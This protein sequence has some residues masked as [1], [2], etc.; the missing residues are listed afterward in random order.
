MISLSRAL[1]AAEPMPDRAALKKVKRIAV[2]APFFCTDTLLR[3]PQSEARKTY[4]ESLQTLERTIQKRL[5]VSLAELGRFRVAPPDLT[6]RSLRALGWNPRDL[7]EEEAAL[8]GA[9]P[10]LDTERAAKLAKKLRVDAVLAA[11]MREPASTKEGYQIAR[12]TWDFNPLSIRFQRYPNHV[13]SPRVQAFL[14]NAEGKVLWQDEQMAVQPRTKPH[15]AK[16]L[17]VDWQEATL[18]VTQHLTENL[19]REAGEFKPEKK[20]I[21]G[22]R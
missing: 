14:V 9:W 2:V 21:A 1:M 4:C 8:F 11:A 15:T 22:S 10:R 7:Y 20:Q 12:N 18:L 19:I 5:P 3:E 13:V 17:C 16:T 6:T